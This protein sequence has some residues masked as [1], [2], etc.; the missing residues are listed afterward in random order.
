[1]ISSK[2]QRSGRNST[3]NHYLHLIIKST[4]LHRAPH[5]APAPTATFDD[6]L[7]LIF[8]VHRNVGMIPFKHLFGNQKS[9]WMKIWVICTIFTFWK[10]IAVNHYSY[11][12]YLLLLRLATIIIFCWTQVFLLLNLLL[13]RFSKLSYTLPAS[14]I[15][16][17]FVYYLVRDNW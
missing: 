15:P 8:W 4:D 6:R 17:I 3:S 11:F 5:T 9:K 10:T 2:F 16:A 7:L 13:L 14:P 1:M 12:L